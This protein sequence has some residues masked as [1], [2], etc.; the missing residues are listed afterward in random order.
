MIIAYSRSMK[1]TR[2]T[3]IVQADFDRIAL[4]SSK[5]SDERWNHNNHY[6]RFLLEQVPAHCRYVLDVG[7]GTGAFARLLAQ[8][9]EYVLAL[10]LSPQMIHQAQADSEGSPNVDF[11][12]ADALGWEFS[13]EHFDYIVSIAALHHMPMEE[14]LSKMKGALAPG[15]TLA[16]LDIYQTRF[17]DLFVSLVS[18]PASLFMQQ[19]KNGHRPKI[20]QEARE[21]MAE[22]V[23]HDSYLPL[24]QVRHIAQTM[25]P[26]AR[27]R[28]H[29]FWRYSLIWKKAP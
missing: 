13:P 23:A 16:V 14:S 22:H 25:L 15:G 11:Q 3:A 24:A 9:T 12:V 10:D 7:C 1:E 4:H 27:V 6:H 26:D 8:H 5:D 28:R 17:S 29:L 21:A 19:L 18:I 2:N 20:S